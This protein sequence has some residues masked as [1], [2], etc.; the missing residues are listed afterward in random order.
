MG[1]T[2]GLIADDGRGH[3][4]VFIAHALELLKKA[5]VVGDHAEGMIVFVADED[6]GQS[7]VGAQKARVAGRDQRLAQ[8]RM[9]RQKALFVAPAVDAHLHIGGELT[10]GVGSGHD[11][12]GAAQKAA[13]VQIHVRAGHA[14][15]VVHF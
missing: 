9:S 12:L 3:D 11:D 10:L 2:I 1:T 13:A 7:G 14:D 4:P 15:L 6:H 5:P 8:G